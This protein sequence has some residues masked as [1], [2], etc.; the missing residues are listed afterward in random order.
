MEPLHS[1]LLQSG[2][3][4]HL[5]NSVHFRDRQ[6]NLPPCAMRHLLLWIL[7]PDSNIWVPIAML[8]ALISSRV[9]SHVSCFPAMLPSH[10]PPRLLPGS[11]AW[12]P[13]P[14]PCRPLR[15]LVFISHPFYSHVF[16]I[17]SLR[18][19]SSSKALQRTLEETATFASLLLL[20]HRSEVLR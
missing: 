5:P 8:I 18:K 4:P 19:T 7:P 2:G 14:L 1:S 13:G 17:T 10:P 15:P 3:W 6:P 11:P 12:H 9:P 16:N 20:L